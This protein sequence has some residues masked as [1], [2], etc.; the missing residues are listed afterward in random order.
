MRRE[1][2]GGETGTGVSWQAGT[3]TCSDPA[4][5]FTQETAGERREMKTVR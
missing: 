4:S 1:A 2:G 3:L 5:L